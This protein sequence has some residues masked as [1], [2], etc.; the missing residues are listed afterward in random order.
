[1]RRPGGIRRVKASHRF[2]G[3]RMDQWR[4]RPAAAGRSVGRNEGGLLAQ[5]GRIARQYR[6][7]GEDGVIGTARDLHAADPPGP[8]IPWLIRP[9][10]RSTVR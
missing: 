9:R 2:G 3:H 8:A 1:M 7:H 10:R 4:G 5:P 6:T